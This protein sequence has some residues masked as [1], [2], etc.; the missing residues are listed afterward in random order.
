MYWPLPHTATLNPANV[1]HPLWCEQPPTHN[2]AVDGTCWC[3]GS[4]RWGGIEHELTG[5]PSK[6][7]SL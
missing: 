4:G 7:G 6:H 3:S 5:D 1:K 2:Y